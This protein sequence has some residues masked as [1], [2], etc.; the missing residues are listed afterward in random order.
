MDVVPLLEHVGA[1]LVGRRSLQLHLLIG[2]Q[3]FQY[4]S[5]ALTRPGQEWTK[6]GAGRPI[7]P[8]RDTP[9]G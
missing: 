5:E 2:S 9:I 1:Q 4:R 7:V 3:A 6:T 8:W